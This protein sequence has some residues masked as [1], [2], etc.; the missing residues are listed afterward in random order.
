MSKRR[1]RKIAAFSIALYDKA[2]RAVAMFM[3]T[4]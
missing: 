1:N 2:Y 3:S 4:S